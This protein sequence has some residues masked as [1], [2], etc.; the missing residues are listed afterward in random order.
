M[1]VGQLTHHTSRITA[2]LRFMAVVLLVAGLCAAQ[3]LPFFELLEHSQ[4]QAGVSAAK[5]PMPLWGW[6]NLVLPAFH[7]FRTHQGVFMQEGQNFF[8]SYYAGLPV[9]ALAGLAV[10]RVRRRMV[11]LLGGMTVMG[12]V[13]AWGEAFPPNRWLR[14]VLPVAGAMRYPVK[15]VVLAAFALPLLAGFA[16]QWLTARSQKAEVRSQTERSL[17]MVGGAML[18]LLGAVLFIA[19]KFP[20]QHDQWALNWQRALGRASFIAACCGVLVAFLRQRTPASGFGLSVVMLAVVWLDLRTHLPDL[21]P[22]LPRVVMTP[23]Y[24][25]ENS[26]LKAAPKPGEGRVFITPAAEKL[27][28]RSPV[29]DLGQDFIGKRFAQWSNLNVLDGVPKVN[30]AATLRVR[31]QDEVQEWIYANPTNASARLPDFLGATH[32]SAPDNPTAWVKRGPVMP[33]VT[34]GQAV[35]FGNAD[36]TRR[37]LLAESFA[38]ER[39]VWLPMEARGFLQATNATTARVRDVSF[40]ANHVEALVESDGPAV[41]VIAQTWYPAWEARVD[42][43]P[44]ILWRAN[45]AFQALE[46]PAGSHRVELR[47]RDRAFERGAWLGLASLAVCAGIIVRTRRGRA[48]V[49]LGT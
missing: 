34:A 31:E 46:V 12:L 15:F 49:N 32:Q 1:L 30:G 7:Y 10:W 20:W 21:N 13:L 33:W 44:A 40:R 47:Y 18:L 22:T 3:L 23:G 16:V 29:T 27:L 25:V 42:G 41:V 6:A 39:E 35:N 17:W 4:R 2:C 14:E 28:L 36:E 24:A 38:P 11:W 19:W 5:W 37:A 26:D 48:G 9:L 8:G 45:H 43:S